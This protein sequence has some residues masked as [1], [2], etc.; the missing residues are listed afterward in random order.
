MI[1]QCVILSPPLIA[2]ALAAEP[3]CHQV[4]NRLSIHSRRSLVGLH[5][6]E[7][8]PDLALRDRERLCLV[9]GLLPSPVGQ[10]SRLNNATPSLQPH[11]R[12]FSATTGCSAPVTAHRYC[13]PRG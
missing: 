11:Y 3:S 13:R 10:W 2:A 8:F 5:T 6:L 9:H 1:R 12:A 4:R 7:G